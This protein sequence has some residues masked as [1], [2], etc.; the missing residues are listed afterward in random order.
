MPIK[1]F[2]V[3]YNIIDT[4]M[5]TLSG[6]CPGVSCM[7]EE[8]QRE[9]VL[10][11]NFQV[12]WMNIEWILHLCEFVN[13][14]SSSTDVEQLGTCDSDIPCGVLS[15]TF[16][17]SIN[18]DWEFFSLKQYPHTVTTT[19]LHTSHGEVSVPTVTVSTLF[20]AALVP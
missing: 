8:E 2:S 4:C 5:C 10:K 19:Y 11:L 1:C 12:N 16:C 9:K 7:V 18:T 13:L 3:M 17:N 20:E 14:T 6:G 15:I